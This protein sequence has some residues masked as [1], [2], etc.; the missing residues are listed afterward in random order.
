MNAA[1]PTPGR[2][3]ELHIRL[4][5]DSPGLAQHELS[6]AAF[7]QPLRRL[8]I[9]FRR[10]A[11]AT[12]GVAERQGA[13]GHQG[14]TFDLHLYSLQ[15]GCVQ[16][17]FR[18]VTSGAAGGGAENVAE[19]AV[20]RV[21][22]AI[23]SEAGGGDGGLPSVRRFLESLPPGVGSQKY[24]GKRD[25]QVFE[26]AEMGG[27]APSRLRRALPRLI[28]VRARVV[29]IGFTPGRGR[30]KLRGEG[31]AVHHCRASDDLVDKAAE[32]R[33]RSVVAKLL[34]RIDGCEILTL[35]A[36]SDPEPVPSDDQ[37]KSYTY[38]RWGEVLH[39]LAQ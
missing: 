14:R 19:A 16:M 21:L 10:A 37:C 26:S 27:P 18:C 31:E 32:L 6:L 39:R 25:G 24:E 9:A 5:G 13:Y 7:S 15:D 30:V 8:V 22:R 3:V 17:G 35:R 11:D 23:R 36:E 12:Q 33:K 2:S 34:A 38:G 29:E 28:T 20:R 4:D 1:A